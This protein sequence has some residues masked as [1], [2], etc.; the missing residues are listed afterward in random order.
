MQAKAESRNLRPEVGYAEWVRF[1]RR[2]GWKTAQTVVMMSLSW[3]VTWVR[4]AKKPYRCRRN[5]ARR[6]QRLNRELTRIDANLGFPYGSPQDGNGVLVAECRHLPSKKV[7]F[8]VF[9]R[10]V[11]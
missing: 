9:C 3:I 4:S 2:E 7:C 11:L 6:E 5:A 10:V 1:A 8:S